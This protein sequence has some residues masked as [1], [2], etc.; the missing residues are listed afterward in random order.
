M[1]SMFISDQHLSNLQQGKH[2]DEEIN[3]EFLLSLDK[4]VLGHGSLN[5]NDMARYLECAGHEGAMVAKI[6]RLKQQRQ[7]KNAARKRFL[8]ETVTVFKTR[9]TSKGYAK[10]ISEVQSKSSEV[11]K[12]LKAV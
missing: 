7:K 6:R 5:V 2:F 3:L 10:A 9:W 11:Q 4:S 8:D 1:E 12:E